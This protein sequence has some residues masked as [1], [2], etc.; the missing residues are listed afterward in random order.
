MSY[1][2]EAL[3]RGGQQVAVTK[4]G[5]MRLAVILLR[6]DRAAGDVSLSGDGW[7]SCIHLMYAGVQILSSACIKLRLIRILRCGGDAG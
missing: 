5:V 7:H 1:S 4:L 2:N 6:A 3:V